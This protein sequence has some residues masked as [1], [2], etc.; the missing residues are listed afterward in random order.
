MR[1]APSQKHMWKDVE[2]ECFE[3]LSASDM[4]M[5]MLP[6]RPLLL[7]LE[8]FVTGVSFTKAHEKSCRVG[9]TAKRRKMVSIWKL[10]SAY[11]PN[12]LPQIPPTA[13]SIHDTDC[14]S[15]TNL[16]LIINNK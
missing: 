2:L 6:L 9:K 8:C 14:R 16:A 4:E 1:K 13:I 15:P 12:K 7:E 3:D 11:P 5:L 10:V